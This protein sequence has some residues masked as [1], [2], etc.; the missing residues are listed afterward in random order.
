MWR[1]PAECHPSALPKASEFC[2]VDMCSL[3]FINWAITLQAAGVFEKKEV[4]D[5][6]SCDREGWH[7]LLGERRRDLENCSYTTCMCQ[8]NLRK[9]IISSKH[10]F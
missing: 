4:E 3:S 6:T 10:T 1:E 5:T 2:L 8:S 7:V 9:R